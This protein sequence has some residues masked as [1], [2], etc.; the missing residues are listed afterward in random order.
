MGD[1]LF[2][3][4]SSARR[5]GGRPEDYAKLHAW[6]DSSKLAG[7]LADWRH[8]ALLHHTFGIHLAEQFFGPFIS[9]SNGDQVAT[10]TVAS[11]HVLEDLG[12]IPSPH[13]WLAE[14]PIRRWMNGASLA[15]RKAMQRGQFLPEDKPLSTEP[16]L[17]ALR[18]VLESEDPQI[19][20][21]ILTRF[22]EKLNEIIQTREKSSSE[23]RLFQTLLTQLKEENADLD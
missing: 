4:L 18:E 12:F 19:R 22:E 15:E 1:V 3:S 13:Q 17:W 11:V 20:E 14:L 5:F 21:R 6:M 7:G 23:A 8:R 16:A 10:R 2:H 9:L